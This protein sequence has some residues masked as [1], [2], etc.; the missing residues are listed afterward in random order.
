MRKKSLLL[1][2]LYSAVLGTIKVTTGTAG[3]GGVR[4]A[5]HAGR[6]G[7]NPGAHNTRPG[8]DHLSHILQ[9]PTWN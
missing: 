2:G 3:S 5:P 8:V 6:E 7:L 1:W 4:G 9:P